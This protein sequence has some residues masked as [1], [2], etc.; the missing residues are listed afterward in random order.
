MM[1][2]VNVLCGGERSYRNAMWTKLLTIPYGE[3]NTLDF[4]YS[5]IMIID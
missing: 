1:Y 4:T 3:T 5:Y 2:N